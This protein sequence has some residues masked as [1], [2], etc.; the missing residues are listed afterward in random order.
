MS[1]VQTISGSTYLLRYLK[2]SHLQNGTPITEC[3]DL[4]ESR[5]PPENHVSFYKA[6]DQCIASRAAKVI[7]CMSFTPKSSGAFLELD[8]NEV[9][10]EVNENKKIIEFKPVG[11]PPHYGMYYSTDDRRERVEAQTVILY[12]SEVI[13][14][15]EVTSRIDKKSNP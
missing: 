15:N 10:G 12:M 2:P 1:S 9:A 6:I 11:T 14:V 8:A 5:T 3:L 13:S 4:R 7:G